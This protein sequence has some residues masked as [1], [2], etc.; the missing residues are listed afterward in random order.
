M[1]YKIRPY[2]KSDELEWL[3]VHASVMVDSYAWWTVIHKKPIYKNDTLDLVAMNKVGKIVGFITI[4]IN[5][6][7]MSYKENYG[8]VWEFGVHRNYRGNNIGFMLI[9]EAHKIMNEQYNAN[10]SIWYSQDENA[11]RYYLHLGMNEISRHMQFSVN[12]SEDLR[13]ELLKDG[14]NCGQMRGTCNVEDF[15]KVKE[16]FDLV[17]DDDALNPQLCIGYEYEL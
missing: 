5:A 15:E 13:R 1:D 7:I 8:F 11:R 10:K 6:D 16:K 14:F 12:P 2:S 9:K 4:E 17:I 3:D